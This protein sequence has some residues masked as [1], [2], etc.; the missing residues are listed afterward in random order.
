MSKAVEK[1]CFL[2]AAFAWLLLRDVCDW[3]DADFTQAG[4]EPQSP[5]QYVSKST[6]NDVL[7]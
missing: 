4:E 1:E 7:F 5:K 6:Q 2:V 3:Y